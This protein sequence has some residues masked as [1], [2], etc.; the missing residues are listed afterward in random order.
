MMPE[1]D[2]SKKLLLP[3]KPKRPLTVARLDAQA[4]KEED[5]VTRHKRL[6]QRR[7]NQK[8]LDFRIGC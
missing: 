2:K 3:P 6:R 7:L 1:K 5:P 4:L 8:F